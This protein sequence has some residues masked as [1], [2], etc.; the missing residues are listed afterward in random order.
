MEVGGRDKVMQGGI[1]TTLPYPSQEKAERI[2]QRKILNHNY[3]TINRRSR[4][5]EKE[6]N[7]NSNIVYGKRER[8]VKD[9][10][11]PREKNWLPTQGLLL[12]LFVKRE[13]P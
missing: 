9:E 10:T 8:K 13:S 11:R 3:K 12:A 6:T 7:E 2:R 4:R 1:T 5:D